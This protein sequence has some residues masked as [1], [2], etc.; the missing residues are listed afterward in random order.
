M[1]G[2]YEPR[3]FLPC[4]NCALC[5]GAGAPDGRG[6]GCAERQVQTLPLR[7]SG[8]VSPSKMLSP[9]VRQQSIHSRYQ[10]RLAVPIIS[11]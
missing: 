4:P 10:K 1:G 5:S 8:V 6:T 11:S 2:K 7:V 3:V 9:T